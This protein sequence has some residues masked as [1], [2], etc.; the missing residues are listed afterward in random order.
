MLAMLLFVERGVAAQTTWYV[1]DDSPPFGSGTS[2][3]AAFDQLDL[4]I[5]SASAGDQIWVAEGT[6]K[7]RVRQSP[8]DPRSVSFDMTKSLRLYGGFAGNET[9]LS[10]RAGLFGTTILD[11]D[12][13][14]P[15]VATD[16]AYHVITA[17][18]VE[19]IDGFTIRNGNADVDAGESGRGGGIH[20]AITTSPPGA[21]LFLSNCTLINNNARQGGALWGQA[22][23]LYAKRCTFRQNSAVSG[24]AIFGN[25]LN[26]LVASCCLIDNTA[27]ANGGAV[28]LSVGG[29]PFQNCVFFNNS[30]QRGGTRPQVQG[31]V[32]RGLWGWLARRG[33]HV[34]QVHGHR[35]QAHGYP[36]GARQGAQGSLRDA[37]PATARTVARLV[38]RGAATGLAVSGACARDAAHHT[39]AQSRLPCRRPL[40]RDR[41]AGV[42][43]Y[44][45]A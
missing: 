1:D 22:G 24:G 28:A 39:P 20:F 27:T 23:Y 12:V 2:W 29:V 15:G 16:N 8:S 10:Q 26:G 33:G 40:G 9:S 21:N 34:A 32:Q 42:A 18:H 11:G 44:A 38:A 37:L 5:D 45:A 13:G 14:I 35:Q 19:V 41:K 31:G 6:Y 7:P 3:A 4:A 30:A 17:K 25:L 36:R 43:A